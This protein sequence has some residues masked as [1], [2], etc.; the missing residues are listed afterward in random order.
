MLSRAQEGSDLVEL[1][2][3]VRQIAR[4]ART[5]ERLLDKMRVAVTYPLP[6]NPFAGGM[7]QAEQTCNQARTW[8]E[9]VQARITSSQS[10]LRPT[11]GPALAF[12]LF[13]ISAILEYR[14]LHIDYVPA[15]LRSLAD[16]RQFNIHNDTI[17][18]IPLSLN[19][20]NQQNAERRLLILL[21]RHET[22][23]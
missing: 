9:S 22:N 5:P 17:W 18:A 15:I 3:L 10:N 8:L 1:L 2:D 4:Q 6:G 23:A 7:N 19:Y 16:K 20:G 14:L 11:P 12:H 21:I 13:V